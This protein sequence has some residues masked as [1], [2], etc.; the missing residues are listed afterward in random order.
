MK[1]PH[2]LST[3]L[4]LVIL[5]SALLVLPL[6]I[7]FLPVGQVQCQLVPEGNCPGTLQTSLQSLQGNFLVLTSFEE[8]VTSLPIPPGY[9][10]VESKKKLPN[11]LQLTFQK[12]SALFQ[13]RCVDCP[14]PLLIGEH[15]HRLHPQDSPV[16]TF[17][18]PYTTT[19]L[20]TDQTLHQ[21]YFQPLSQIVLSL[22]KQGL[23]FQNGKWNSP[24]EVRLEVADKPELIVS[25][26]AIDHQ[27]A[28]LAALLSGDSLDQIPEPVRE[29][30]LRYNMPVI[31]TR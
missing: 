27:L 17:D 16:P 10:L 19:E 22:Y 23:I 5:F 11:T 31:R 7:V 6:S 2:R 9:A 15:S 30:D 28:V 8:K 20:V 13:V 29:I 14:E 18:M 3:F 21:I 4:Q 26:E 1:L 25:T 12:E 24:E